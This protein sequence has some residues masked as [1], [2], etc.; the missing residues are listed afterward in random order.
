MGSIRNKINKIQRILNMNDKSKEK[1][2]NQPPKN[3]IDPSK[4][5][6]VPS[7]PIREGKERVHYTSKKQLND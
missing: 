4:V 6:K 5:K 3:V 2:Q 7:N 1:P